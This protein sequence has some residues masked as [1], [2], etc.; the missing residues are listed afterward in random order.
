MQDPLYFIYEHIGNTVVC[1]L[2]LENLPLGLR[3]D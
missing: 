1:I 3:T 2:T